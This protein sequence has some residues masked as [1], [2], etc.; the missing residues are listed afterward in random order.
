M[1]LT[2]QSVAAFTRQLAAK[3][4]IPGG[5]GASALVGALGAALGSMVGR[6][7]VGNPRYAAAEEEVTAI[8]AQLEVLQ[9][10]LLSLVEADAAAFRPLSR[11]Y[12][13]PKDDPTRGEVLERCLRQ[14]AEPPMEL[15]RLSCQAIELHQAL[16]DKGS[17]MLLS[18]VGTGVIF[19]WSALYGAWLN[20]KV[21]TKP[22]A[23]RAYAEG[24]NAQAD[25]LV[26]RYW[27][28]ADQVY[29]AVLKRYS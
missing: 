1:D 3:T 18:D 21:N 8:L 9:E 24:L 26:E 5:G 19:C 25:A 17:A 4:P 13:I 11:A 22:M 23:D 16:L 28:V 7:T 2:E 10:K 29:E 27:K 20:L 14:A 6:Y 12:A 15:L